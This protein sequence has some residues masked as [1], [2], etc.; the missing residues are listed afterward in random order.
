MHCPSLTVEVVHAGRTQAHA[1]ESFRKHRLR[2]ARL[3]TLSSH[4]GLG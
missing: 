4:L 2:F 1:S 3:R